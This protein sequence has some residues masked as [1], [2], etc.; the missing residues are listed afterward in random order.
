MRERCIFYTSNDMSQVTKDGFT[1][2]I[3]DEILAQYG[4]LVKL[5]LNTESMD[6]NEKQYW[7]DIMPSMTDD[8]I[9]RLFDILDTERKKLEELE[10]KY[11]EEIRQ[12]NESQ[13]IEWQEFQTR[14]QKKKIQAAEANDDDKNAADDALKMLNM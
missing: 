6:F 12:L 2:T 13:L 4:E 11:Q 14:E 1:F 5:I 8:Q 10:V 9:D 7:F 3:P